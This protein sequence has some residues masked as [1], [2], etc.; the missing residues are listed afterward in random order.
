[1]TCFW[2]SILSSLSLEDYKLLGVN[3]KLRREEFIQTLKNKNCMVDTLWMSSIL[4]DQEKKEHF[5]AI[6]CYNIKGI[7]NGHLTSICD[8]FLLL[9]SHLLKVNIN[10]MYL[11]TQIVYS[12]PNGAR[13]TLHFRSD[14]GHFSR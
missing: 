12:N 10:H 6:K 11:K 8:S 9:I 7:R 2:E 5:E 13:K 14:R 3:R 1:M 4:R